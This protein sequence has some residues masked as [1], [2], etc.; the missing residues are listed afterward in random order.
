VPPLVTSYNVPSALKEQRQRFSKSQPKPTGVKF[1]Q[2]VGQELVR[3]Q[4]AWLNEHNLTRY[5][6]VGKSANGIE[7][8]RIKCKFH[9]PN[10]FF[11]SIHVATSIP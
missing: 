8:A 7:V 10:A 11:M 4:S 5:R 9:Q 6:K 3:D 2:R 1:G